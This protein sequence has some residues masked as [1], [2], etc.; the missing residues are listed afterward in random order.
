MIQ[1]YLIEKSTALLNDRALA[2]ALVLG[3]MLIASGIGSY[4]SGKWERNTGAGVRLAWLLIVVWALFAYF[5]L[6]HV[7]AA[8]VSAPAFAKTLLVIVLVAAISVPLG[9]PFSLGLVTLKDVPAFVPWAW[10]LNGAFSVIA[11]P[12]ANLLALSVGLR[13]LVLLG[14]ILYTICFISLPRNRSAS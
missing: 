6:D 11:T 12:L 5:A 13:T 3:T 8:A 1:I 2:F 7:L 14:A 10:S 9:F 4:L